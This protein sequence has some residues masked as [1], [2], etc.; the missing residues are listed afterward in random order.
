TCSPQG[1]WG[2]CVLTACNDSAASIVNGACVVPAVV[3][4][5]M[6]F[7]YTGAPPFSPTAPTPSTYVFVVPNYTTLTVKLWGGGGGDIFECASDQTQ[8][9]LSFFTAFGALTAGSGHGADNSSNGTCFCSGST[10]PNNDVPDGR[11]G[12]ASGGTININGKP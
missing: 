10:C 6:K 12:V 8:P 4:G 2:N 7:S 1:A 9:N 5:S 3:P 11:G